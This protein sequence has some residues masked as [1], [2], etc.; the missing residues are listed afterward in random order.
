MNTGWQEIDIHGSYSL[1]KIN[2]TLRQFARARTIDEYDVTITVHCIRVT[3]VNFDDVTM[4][5]QK[6][7]SCR[8]WRNERS[9]IVFNGSV[10]SDH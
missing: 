6:R 2:L 8:Q 1:T 9:I 5:S 7:P 3:E 4:V 10:C